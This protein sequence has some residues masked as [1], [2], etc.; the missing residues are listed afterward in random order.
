MKPTSHQMGMQIIGM[1]RVTASAG[2]AAPAASRPR[3][4]LARSI[5]PTCA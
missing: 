2:L 3:H 1:T 4:A 5:T